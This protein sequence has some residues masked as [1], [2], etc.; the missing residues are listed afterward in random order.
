MTG[1]WPMRND[2][3]WDSETAKAYDTPDTGMFSPELL[4]PTVDRLAAL[5]GEGG[6]LEFAIGTGRV[7]VPLSGRGVSVT[8]VELSIRMIDQ[9]RTKAGSRATGR[10]FG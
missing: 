9:L 7:A 3:I 10:S 8:P 5:V 1:K 6:A 2:D 4:R